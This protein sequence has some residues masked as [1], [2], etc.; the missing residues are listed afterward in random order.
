MDP[1]CKIKLGHHRGKTAVAKS[2]GT[3]PVWNDVITLQKKHKEEFAKMKV[4]DNDKLRINDKI[5]EAKIPLG[6]IIAKGT[7]NQ[8][9]PVFKKDKQTG[10]VLMENSFVPKD[11]T[12]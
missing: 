6:E 5:G 4:K 9:Y 10:E 3:N 2:E 8:W 1:Y 11:T 12:V 7:V